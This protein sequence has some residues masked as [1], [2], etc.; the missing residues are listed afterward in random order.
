MRR[1]LLLISAL[2]LLS[3]AVSAQT[4]DELIAKTPAARG[5]LAKL[6]AVQ[7][8]RLTGSFETNGM[9]A[10][11]VEVAKR[12]NKL[13]RDI[14]IQGLTLVQA[15]DGKSGW[16]INPFTGK[17]DPEAMSG[18]ELKSIQEEADTD[19][20]LLD[21]KQKGNKIEL[22]G[23]EK[24]AGKDA[25]NLKVTLRSGTVRNIYLDAASFFTVKTTG[26]VTREGTE[27]KIE[28]FLSDFKEANGIV[29][30]FTIEVQIDG[31]ATSQKITFEKVEFN[32]PVD[33]SVFNM[34]APAPTPKP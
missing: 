1:L 19:G 2:L 34:P 7:S 4:V 32:V 21:Y 3:A 28:S 8:V 26:T 12:P 5:G 27:H 16:Q 24:V 18:D 30:P 31:G 6:K 20:P 25:Y 33:D 23:K 9:Q 29:V 11:F 15:Y 22:V 13:R 10:G 17:P 14:S